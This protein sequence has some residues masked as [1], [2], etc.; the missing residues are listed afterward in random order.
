MPYRS[1][2]PVATQVVAR[3][4][5]VLDELPTGE[6]LPPVR[7]LAVLLGARRDASVLRAGADGFS[8]GEIGDRLR[9]SHQSVW[10]RYR[11]EEQERSPESSGARSGHRSRDHA[12]PSCAAYSAL[13]RALSGL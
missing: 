11:I 9:M 10:S 13:P 6:G 4:M 7:S 5:A 12:H 1:V 8:W 3:I 2:T